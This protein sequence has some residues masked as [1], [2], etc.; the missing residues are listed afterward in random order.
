MHRIVTLH[1]KSSRFH[2]LIQWICIM[3]DGWTVVCVSRSYADI[4][5]LYWETEVTT[6]LSRMTSGQQLLWFM[7][8]FQ[9]CVL[10]SLNQWA[11][12]PDHLITLVLV[13]C[14]MTRNRNIAQTNSFILYLYTTFNFSVHITASKFVFRLLCD[15]KQNFL[16]LY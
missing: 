16:K 12:L 3:W 13:Q 14:E 15:Q 4:Q 7:L 11:L 10:D 9:C 5:M 8:S 1:P 2:M 6:S